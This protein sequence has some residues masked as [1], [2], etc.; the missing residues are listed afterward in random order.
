MGTYV[1]IRLYLEWSQ[2]RR[3]NE[4]LGDNAFPE[5]FSPPYTVI[6]LNINNKGHGTFYTLF[7]PTIWLDNSITGIQYIHERNDPWPIYINGE[8]FNPALEY[9]SNQQMQR[10]R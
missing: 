10:T 9:D 5:W 3:F 7:L 1:G 6:Y 4:Y 8:Y 2:Q